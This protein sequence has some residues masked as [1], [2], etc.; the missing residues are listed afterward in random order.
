[1]KVS[2]ADRIDA[3]AAKYPNSMTWK[4]L[5]VLSRS[6]H[7]RWAASMCRSQDSERAS[8]KIPSVYK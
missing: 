2:A 1:M 3:F 6:E 8:K 7:S 4:M 5:H